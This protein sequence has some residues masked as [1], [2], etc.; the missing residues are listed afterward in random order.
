MRF[1][2]DH[3]VDVAVCQVL[4]DAGHDCWRAPDGLALDGVDDEISV[5]ADDKRAVVVTHD[6]VF[7]DI[8][9]K[10]TFGQ[11]VRLAC[12]HP[13]AARVM[14]DRLPE[15]LDKLAAGTGVYTVSASRVVRHPPQ[16][17]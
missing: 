2:I 1:V 17:K 8:R 13:H 6:R 10:A 16:W 15:L 11:H 3:D 5:Y 7:T 14:R 4:T 12:K 9:K